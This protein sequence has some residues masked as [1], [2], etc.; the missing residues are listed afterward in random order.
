MFLISIGMGACIL[1][2]LCGSQWV[3]LTTQGMS[4]KTI[5]AFNNGLWKECVDDGGAELLCMDI[6]NDKRGLSSKSTTWLKY[7]RG[8]V[9]AS[10]VTASLVSIL[11]A[12][13]YWQSKVIYASTVFALFTGIKMVAALVIFQ[14]NNH[15]T[16]EYNF[17]YG[18]S[19][20]LGISG[21]CLAGLTFINGLFS[22]LYSEDKDS[23]PY[24]FCRRDEDDQKDEVCVQLNAV[25]VGQVVNV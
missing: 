1:A 19:F 11:T 25:T 4:G 3:T 8:F 21:A 23:K 14:R 24:R 18:S 22:I 5:A 2:S 20:D 9:I 6:E 10:C 17:Q 12:V 13:G 16:E 15:W 7:V